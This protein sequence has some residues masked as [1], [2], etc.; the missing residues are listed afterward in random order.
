MEPWCSLLP[1]TILTT[2]N[3]PGQMTFLILFLQSATPGTATGVPFRTLSST[4]HSRV[5]MVRRVS[6]SLMDV[7]LDVRNVMGQ[8][9]DPAS[10][11]TRLISVVLATK[12]QS[13]IPNCE[14]STLG[15]S[16]GLSRTVTTTVPGEPLA[17]PQC[18]IPVV[19][20]EGLPTREGSVLSTGT[21]PT[22]VRETGAARLWTLVWQVSRLEIISF[23]LEKNKKYPRQ[24]PP[25]GGQDPRSMCPGPSQVI[26]S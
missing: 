12:R 26:K 14:L 1:G 25:H 15:P 13:V 16:A 3:I 20:L 7:P 10:T 9:E 11:P 4:G 5:T 21:Q 23:I 24:V 17:V 8:H 6:G 2:R 22:P 19:W 18:L